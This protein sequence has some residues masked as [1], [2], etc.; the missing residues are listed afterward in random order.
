[1]RATKA[2]VRMR[3]LPNVVWRRRIHGCNTSLTLKEQA[4]DRLRVLRASLGR[5]RAVGKKLLP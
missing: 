2:G 5:R 1:M 4:S 3:L